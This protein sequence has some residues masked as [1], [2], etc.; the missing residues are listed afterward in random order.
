MFER[1]LDIF[2]GFGQKDPAFPVPSDDDVYP[3]YINDCTHQGSS[4]TLLMRFNDVLDPEKLHASLAH[5]LE[6]GD[7]RKLG[8][9]SRSDKAGEYII[10]VPKVF[11]PQRP[12][13]AYTQK[14]FN[15]DIEQHPWGNQLPMPTNKLSVQYTIKHLTSFWEETKIPPNL[16]VI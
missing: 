11:T 9:R 3:L 12:A 7:W 15:I 2:G 14:T 4:I 6:I 16:K 13:V 1:I 10:H 5:L 8:G